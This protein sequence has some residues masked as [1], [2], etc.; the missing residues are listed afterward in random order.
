MVERTSNGRAFRI[1]N[2]IAEFTRECLA[3]KIARKIIS[4]DVIDALFNLFVFRP[5]AN[6]SDSDV[7]QTHPNDE[8]I[9]VSLQPL[10]DCIEGTIK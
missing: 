6:I 4:Q 10:S 5:A 7:P 2:I 1:L 8:S 3:I 9:F